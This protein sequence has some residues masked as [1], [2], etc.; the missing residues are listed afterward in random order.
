MDKEKLNE[1]Y[2]V[3]RSI[4]S[5]EFQ[6][7]V[8]KPLYAEVDKLKSAFDCKS[9]AELS[10]LKGKKWGLTKMI[11]IFKQIETDI[12]STKFELESREE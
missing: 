9:L 11:G 3:K 2:A 10:E 5:K 4:E 1:L 8:M 6:F 7:Y 12:K